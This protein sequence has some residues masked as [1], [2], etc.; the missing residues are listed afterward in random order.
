MEIT[1]EQAKESFI[2]YAIEQYDHSESLALQIAERKPKAFWE[3]QVNFAQEQVNKAIEEYKDENSILYDRLSK[4][5]DYLMQVGDYP[6]DIGDCF[7]SFGFGPNG[8]YLH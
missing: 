6:F 3:L 4:G 1:V 2:Q 7:E 5:R 8:E